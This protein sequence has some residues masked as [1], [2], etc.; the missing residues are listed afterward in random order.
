MTSQSEHHKIDAKSE[1]DPDLHSGQEILQSYQSM[2]VTLS[3]KG[4][5]E[6]DNDSPLRNQ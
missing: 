4:S 3:K 5:V 1:D 2:K 6:N